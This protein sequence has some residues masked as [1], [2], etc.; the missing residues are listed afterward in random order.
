MFTWWRKREPVMTMGPVIPNPVVDPKSGKTIDDVTGETL[1]ESGDPMSIRK[2]D[3]GWKWRLLRHQADQLQAKV[4]ELTANRKGRVTVTS[5]KQ[6]LDEY[7]Q[8]VQSLAELEA[9]QAKRTTV[10]YQRAMKQKDDAYHAI[11]HH[12]FELN[13]ETPDYLDHLKQQA[14]YWDGKP[15][16][17]ML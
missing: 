8:C 6:L 14:E 5:T 11:L 9:V 10:I 15:L 17:P 7:S 3:T 2:R 1:D 4:D 16:H 13:P 12:L